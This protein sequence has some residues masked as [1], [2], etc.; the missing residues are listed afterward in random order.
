[1]IITMFKPFCILFFLLLLTI[2]FPLSASYE[3]TVINTQQKA[4]NILQQLKPLFT[5][6]AQFSAK[7][8]QLII[9]ASPDVIKEVKY[10]LKQID[11][12]LKNLIIHVANKKTIN[13]LLKSTPTSTQYKTIGGAT[14]SVKTAY[15]SGAGTAKII[16]TQR[17]SDSRGEGT[18]QARVIEGN[19]VTIHMDKKIPYH[20]VGYPSRYKDRWVQTQYKKITNGFDAKVVLKPNK[21][22]IASIK[23]QNHYQDNQHHDIINTR[24]TETTISGALDEW[25]EIGQI[26]NIKQQQP[27]GIQYNS[28]QS[29]SETSYYI[30]VNAVLQP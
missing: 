29:Q 24:S 1:M 11:R 7:D 20:T 18:F 19:W 10:L 27:S 2:S 16:S 6:Q 28:S 4:E 3:Y 5:E 21:Q 9:K 12:P 15:Q 26:S 22:I 8:Y 25:I 17:R 14:D 23:I 30:K 13:Q